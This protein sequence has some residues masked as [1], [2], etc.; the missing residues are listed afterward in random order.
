VQNEARD[1]EL[2]MRQW[3]QRFD[4]ARD[5][6]VARWGEHMYRAFRL[7]LWGG[8]R[9]FRQDLMQAY[10]IVAERRLERGP[11]PGLLGRCLNEV[12]SAF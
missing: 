1:Y 10:S 5:Q 3:A 8:S 11:R 6:I 7:Y 2:T 9:A 12:K 4:E